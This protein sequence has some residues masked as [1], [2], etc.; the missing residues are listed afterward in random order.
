MW[1]QIEESLRDSM[2]RVFTK[3]ATLLPGILAFVLVLLIFLIINN[4]Y[5]TFV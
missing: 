1:Q 2:G 3:I 5:A 4:H